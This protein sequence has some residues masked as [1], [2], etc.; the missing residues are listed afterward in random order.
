MQKLARLPAMDIF[1]GEN[2]GTTSV[3]VRSASCILNTNAK[4]IPLQVA[5]SLGRPKR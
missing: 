1:S 4:N 3:A 5:M 2:L